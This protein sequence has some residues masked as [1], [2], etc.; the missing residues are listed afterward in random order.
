MSRRKKTSL[1]VIDTA[2][3]HSA[4]MQSIDPPLDLGNGLSLTALRKALT[5][6]QAKLSAYNTLLSQVDEAYNGFKTAEQTLR[7]LNE[8]M[9][10]GIAAKYVRDSDQYEMAGGK[11]KSERRRPL[12]K[13][14]TPIA[15]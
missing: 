12:R 10:A 6:A 8:R 15:A 3:T 11:R 14:A 7:D 2:S 13:V 5:G 1:L 9:L 4:G